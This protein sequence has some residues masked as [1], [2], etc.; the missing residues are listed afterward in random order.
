MLQDDDL[1][2]ADRVACAARFLNDEDLAAALESLRLSMVSKGKL[3]GLLLTGL[4]PAAEP[5][6]RKVVCVELAG[7]RV[8]CASGFCAEV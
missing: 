6:L 5:L 2:L 4:A 3:E 7:T 1:A 8:A